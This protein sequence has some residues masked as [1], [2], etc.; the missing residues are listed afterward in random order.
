MKTILSRI[1]IALILTSLASV[2]AFAKTKTE[3]IKLPTNIKINGTAVS[4][5]TY[6]LKFD[7]ETGELTIVKDK[8]VVARAVASVEK[9]DTKAREFLLRSIG[10]GDDE[11]LIGI[12]FGGADHNVVI[13]GSQ[14]SR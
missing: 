5:G 2:T 12:T 10:R 14:A 7:Y 4:K 3:K 8:K 11:Q 6:D 9:R 1:A 13:N